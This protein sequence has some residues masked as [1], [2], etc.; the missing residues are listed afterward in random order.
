MI[1]NILLIYEEGIIMKKILKNIIHFIIGIFIGIGIAYGIMSL[2]YADTDV[3][4]N[5]IL[6]YK[7]ENILYVLNNKNDILSQYKVRI[8]KNTKCKSKEGDQATP[9]GEYK[10]TRIRKHPKYKIFMDINYPN[11]KDKEEGKTGNLIGIHQW[12]PKDPIKYSQGCI[13]VL[14]DGE[15]EEIAKNV[16][17]GT[18][19]LIYE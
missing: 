15:I 4:T 17:I 11:K 2:A 1:N 6:I 10:I 7:Q 5:K 12:Y 9:C 8:G 18:K 14:N 13:T 19:V 16:M 3:N